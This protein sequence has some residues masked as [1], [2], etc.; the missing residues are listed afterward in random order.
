MNISKMRHSAVCLIALCLNS[1]SLP[2][3]S[4]A[5]TPVAATYVA[6]SV[7]SP[8]SALTAEPKSCQ[9]AGSPYS[10]E[11]TSGLSGVLAVVHKLDNVYFLGGSPFSN[12]QVNGLLRNS[13][14]GAIGLSPD[15]STFAYIT[16]ASNSGQATRVVL[17]LLQ[18]KI[19]LLRNF[20]YYYESSSF[21]AC[22]QANSHCVA[23]TPIFRPFFKH[24]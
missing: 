12:N 13:G 16:Q 20:G 24:G 7:T 10:I 17:L 6:S 8:T 1:C 18:R 21:T 4:K 3:N 22:R 2:T 19:G 11:Q 15:G 23:K 5:T 9:N 14:S